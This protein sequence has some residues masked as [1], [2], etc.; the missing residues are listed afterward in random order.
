MFE[1]GLFRISH[2]YPHPCTKYAKW[3]ARAREGVFAHRA[4]A[5]LDNHL[6]P[7]ATSKP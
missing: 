2:M 6:T 5:D 4:R 7:D 1:I 3:M